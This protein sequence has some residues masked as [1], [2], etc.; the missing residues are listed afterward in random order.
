MRRL[1]QALVLLLVWSTASSAQQ[2][3]YYEPFGEVSVFRPTSAPRH[4]AIVISGDA[5]LDP[6]ARTIAEQLAPRATLVLGVDLGQYRER[7]ATGWA[8]E[9]YPSADLELLSQFAQ[10]ALR[11]TAYESPVLVGVGAGAALVY[12]ALAEANP[13]AFRGA[14]SVGFCPRLALP[15]R[16]GHG[17]NLDADP[18]DGG[19]FRFVPPPQVQGRWVVIR[20]AHETRCPIGVVRAFVGH[21]PHA[22][23]LV[24]SGS[25]RDLGDRAYRSAIDAALDGVSHAVGDEDSVVRTADVTNL[26]LVEVRAR[27]T[28]A[29]TLAV[30]FSGD[31]GWASIDRDV[32]EE[33]ASRGIDVVGL[34]S[35]RY[36]WTR[37]TPDGAAADLD[38]ILRHYLAAWHAR[39]IFLLGYSRGADVLPFLASR[40]PRSLRDRVAAVVLLGPTMR[41]DFEFHLSDW[42]ANAAR[43]T[44]LRVRPE[45]EKLRGMP[46]VCV[47]GRDETDSLCPDLPHGLATVLARPGGHHF[48][49]DYDA[50]VAR[51]LQTAGG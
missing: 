48:G 34:N 29:S 27:G 19:V 25:G 50:I 33:L 41:V 42:I 15:N 5:G 43:T 51:V 46:L 39:R 47:Y 35:L 26:P 9:V 13:N 31:G 11:V 10:R 1:G 4:V 40:L 37:R 6:I 2:I 38:R 18:I 44:E 23:L 14:I 24:V 7:L 28:P 8:D 16:P 22:K 45:V 20:D 12:A 30:M 3:L 17:R 21:V 49:G 32:G 36:F